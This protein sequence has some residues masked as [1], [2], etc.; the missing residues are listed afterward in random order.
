LP[1]SS[2]APELTKAGK[3]AILHDGSFSSL[4]PQLSGTAEGVDVSYD[5]LVVAPGL[6]VDFGAVAVL[7]QALHGPA[8]R[9]SSIYSDRAVE[10]IRTDVQASVMQPLIHIHALGL[11]DASPARSLVLLDGC[12]PVAPSDACMLY[13]ADPN[14]L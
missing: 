14:A 13:T 3:I 4:V 10:R 12:S 1:P 9:V 5:Y 8:S 11:E 2:P 6:E 7:E